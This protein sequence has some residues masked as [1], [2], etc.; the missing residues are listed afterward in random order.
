MADRRT[1]EV[2]DQGFGEQS[3]YIAHLDRGWSLLARGQF[4]EARNS[5]NHAHQINSDVP[6]ASMLLAA[7]SVE[8][9]DPEG[10]LEWY[11]RAIDADSD[12]IDAH[13]AAIQVRLYD[14]RDF[15][16][17]L[18]HAERALGLPDAYMADLLDLHLFVL[19]ALIA[20]RSMERAND[21]LGAVT[22]LNDLL[23]ILKNDPPDDP[24][25]QLIEFTGPLDPDDELDGET[26]DE[27]RERRMMRC[28]AL[29][30]RS[31]RVFL[32]L[33]RS[34]D[35]LGLTRDLVRHVPDQ[36][37]A[38]YLL[39][40]AEHTC[41]DHIAAIRAALETYRL[42]SLAKLPA[43]MPELDALRSM[44]LKLVKSVPSLILAP[45]A[46]NPQLAVVVHES[47]ALELILEGIDPRVAVVALGVRAD[48]DGSEEKA[49]PTLTGV[50]IY[51]Q[52]LARFAASEETLEHELHVG[53]LDELSTYL[54]MDNNQREALG[55]VPS[56]AS[57]SD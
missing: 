29:G 21:R 19:E 31:A 16:G 15:E 27:D 10:A 11:D 26:D 39:N 55:L 8:E 51:R 24:S 14:M 42:D 30:T 57:P 40:E 46:E 43:W 35:A 7:I 18:L 6:D 49:Q 48:I 36:A 17:A 28:V 3:R 13:L 12:C 41:G 45:A 47:P 2:H 23:Q 53:I 25:P 20:Q 44:A 1:D 34:E 37:D 22:G 56:S 4:S 54:G 50:A 38:W 33:G 5:A 9:G 32:D 52:N